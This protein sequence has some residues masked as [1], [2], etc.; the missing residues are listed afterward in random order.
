MTI[1]KTYYGLYFKK[2]VGHKHDWEYAI[3]KWIPDGSGNFVRESVVLEVHGKKGGGAYSDISHTF[4]GSSD[5]F[6]D[7]NQGRD[8][9]KFYFGKRFHSVHWD[10]ESKNKATC[11]QPE[12][13]A[14]DFQFWSSSHLRHIDNIDQSWEFGDASKPHDT[15]AGMC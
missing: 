12:F 2:D 8:H 13:R 4:D 3:L 10:M 7:W 11:I 1:Q 5:Q 9:P 6:E 15:V 14:N